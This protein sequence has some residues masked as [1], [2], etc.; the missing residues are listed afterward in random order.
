MAKISS[1][2]IEQ[3]KNFADIVS[4]VAEYVKLENR[5]GDFWGCCPFHN[6][7]TPSFHVVPDRN[8]FHCFGCG[9]SGT[10]ITFLM[11]IEQISYPEAIEFIAADELIEVTPENIR[12]R[13]KIL[14][15]GLRAKNRS[16][17]L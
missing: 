4:V 13:K 2:T 3:V 17:S 6:E 14:D 15:N 10:S 1:A 16:K 8:F 12:I 11:E 5:G 9:K 7:K